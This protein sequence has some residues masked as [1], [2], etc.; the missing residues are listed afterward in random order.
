MLTKLRY[1]TDSVVEFDL[2][3]DALV[4]HCDAP[5]GKP[6]VDVADAMRTALENP[7]DFPPLAKSVVPG[8]KVAIALDYAVPQAGKIVAGIVEALIAADIQPEDI[9]IVR[10]P[11]DDPSIDPRSALTEDLRSVVGLVTHDPTIRERLS[12]LGASNQAKPVYLNREICEADVVIPVGIAR[13]G[14]S[15]GYAG[16]ASGV[17]P[18]F[19]D[20]PTLQRY[21]APRLLDSAERLEKA[22][23]L[24]DEVSWLLGVLFAVQVVPGRFPDVLHIVA[25]RSDL[26]YSRSQ[27]LCEAAW[28]FSVPHRASVVVA[29]VEGTN[30]CQTWDNLARALYAASRS[31]S[32]EGAIVLCTELAANAG[33]AIQRLC[34]AEDVDDV[35]REI[36]KER[37]VDTLVAVEL[38]HALQRGPL[39]LISRLDEALVEDLGIANVTEQEEVARLVARH[40]SCI[41]LANAQHAVAIPE[42]EEATI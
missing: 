8:D 34:N 2:P 29:A 16:P 40:D 27:E 1:G 15:M 5:R 22:R 42:G 32:E 37:P 30:G 13:V 7:L 17:F 31:V 3:D 24:A 11:M 14:S 18:T 19:S 38:A 41:L 28:R 9:T 12:Y 26:V 39:Y 25:G 23:A 20:E 35:L 10:T 36:S 4:A 6:I 33:P 21:R